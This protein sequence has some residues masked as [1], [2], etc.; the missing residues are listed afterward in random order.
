MGENVAKHAELLHLTIVILQGLGLHS[1]CS[2]RKE[3]LAL[4]WINKNTSIQTSSRQDQPTCRHSQTKGSRF[5]G[6]RCQHY[7]CL[8][9][10]PSLAKRNP[11][12]GSPPSPPIS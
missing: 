12:K 6:K 10:E 4:K 9:S 3:G 1:G 11:S 7:W 5:F 2:V 8:L